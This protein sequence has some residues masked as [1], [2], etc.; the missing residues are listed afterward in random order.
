M[1]TMKNIYQIQK[2]HKLKFRLDREFEPG[3]PA[4][5][6]RCSTTE[7]PRQINSHG[8]SRPNYHI[9][10]FTKIF[11]HTTNTCSPCNDLLILQMMKDG[12]STKFN[13]KERENKMPII[14]HI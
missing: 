8:P 7:L 13:R 6:V 4:S 12:H 2:K 10:P 1:F 5:L 14:Y 11:K 9:P 3:T